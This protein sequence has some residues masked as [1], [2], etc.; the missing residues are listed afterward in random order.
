MLGQ[1]RFAIG[2]LRDSPKANS[3]NYF[4]ICP[5]GLTVHRTVIQ[6]PQAASLLA[7][8]RSPSGE[9]SYQLFSNTLRP[10]RYP[11]SGGSLRPLRGPRGKTKIW[12]FKILT[13]YF[14]FYFTIH[15]LDV[16]RFVWIFIFNK[17]LFLFLFYYDII[18][19]LSNKKG[20]KIHGS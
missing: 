13:E 6:Y 4:V 14:S 8:A 2:E 17:L 15:L 9:N 19:L 10:L 18:N 11:K 1:R 16:G 5:R 12:I 7:A 3:G 20:K